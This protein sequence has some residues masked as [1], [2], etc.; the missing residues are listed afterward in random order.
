MRLHLVTLTTDFGPGSHYVAALKGVILSLNPDADILDL[1]H[2]ILPQQIAHGAFFLAQVVRYFPPDAVHLAVVDPGVGTDRGLIY[3]RMAHQHFLAPDNGL[4]SWV[5][6]RS[7]PGSI[8]TLRDPAYWRAEVSATFHARDI[9]APVAAHLTLGLDPTKLGPPQTDL[10][11]LPWPEP[12]RHNDSIEGVILFED[13]FGN[14]ITNLDRDA[15]QAIPLTEAH[16]ELPSGTRLNLLRTYADAPPGTP[17]ALIGSTGHLELAVAG[18][19]AAKTLGLC[20][21]DAVLVRSAAVKS[22]IS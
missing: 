1:S 13:S 17:L 3:A 4:L 10:V 16:V 14:L 22:R 8:I 20:P 6:R 12:R 9:L 18:G 11:R 19:S 15:L 2:A 7:P 5:A 21:G